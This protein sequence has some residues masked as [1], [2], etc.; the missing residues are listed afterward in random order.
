MVLD[1][2]FNVL[3][4][5]KGLEIILELKDRFKDLNL[6]CILKFSTFN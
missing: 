4:A 5:K 2:L 3:N 6:H 1:V